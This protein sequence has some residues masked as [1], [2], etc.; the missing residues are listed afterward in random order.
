MIAL[1]EGAVFPM[2]AKYVVARSTVNAETGCWEWA[3]YKCSFGHGS[4]G[5][6][7]PAK[8]Y[9]KTRAHNIAWIAYNG[10][11]SSDLWVL[12]KCL[13]HSCCNPKHLYL[14]TAK[15][16]RA[17]AFKDG[18]AKIPDNRG[19]RCGTSKLTEEDVMKIRDLSKTFSNTEIGGM[20]GV[21][22]QHV[23]D[24]LRRKCWRHI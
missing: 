13:T 15:D 4:C 16:N 18:N 5:N 12:H 14:G 20:F 7:W 23:G 21:C 6:S 24:I 22:R 9:H 19:E 17:D 1:C 3:L 11:Y 10:R 8:L 2:L